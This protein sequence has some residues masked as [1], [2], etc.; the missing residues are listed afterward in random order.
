MEKKKKKKLI[1]KLYLIEPNTLMWRTYSLEKDPDAGKDWGQEEK[2]MAE[3]EMVGWHH[4]L[5]AHESE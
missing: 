2:G 1:F 3:N 4:Q 5:D